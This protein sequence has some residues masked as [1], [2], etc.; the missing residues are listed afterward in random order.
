MRDDRIPAFLAS[1]GTTPARTLE[2][3]IRGLLYLYI[4]SLP[5]QRLLVLERNIFLALLVLL[6]LWCLVSRRHFLLATSID[7][8]L[9]MFVAWVG[10][11]LLFAVYPDYSRKEFGKLLQQ[12]VIFYAVVYFFARASSPRQSAL[13]SAR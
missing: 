5:F 7:L 1:Q 12:V 4:F 8:P 2:L 13:S 10:F 9:M 3:I 11:T 6:P